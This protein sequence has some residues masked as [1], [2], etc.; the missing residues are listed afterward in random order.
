[1]IFQKKGGFDFENSVFC[2]E[3]YYIGM[4]DQFIQF[5]MVSIDILN[6]VLLYLHIMDIGLYRILLCTF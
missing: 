6:N 5:K 4:F 1:M 2:M 3:G